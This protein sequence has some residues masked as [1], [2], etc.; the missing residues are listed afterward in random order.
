[1][2]VCL[3]QADGC[4]I[5]IDNPVVYHIHFQCVSVIHQVVCYILNAKVK[6]K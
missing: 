6:I 5:E 2:S 3:L 4:Q 1:M